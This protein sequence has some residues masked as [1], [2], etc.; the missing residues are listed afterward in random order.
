MLLSGLGLSAPLWGQTPPAEAAGQETETISEIRVRGAQKLSAETVS[1]KAGVKVGDDLRSMDFSAMLERLWASN[2]FDDVKLDVEET[3]KGSILIITVKER[4]IIKEIDYRGGTEI[5]VTTMKDKIKEKKLEAKA[6][7]IYDPEIARKIKNQIV[8]LA[9][10]KGF[11]NPVVEVV[12]EPM[13]PGVARLVFDV[14]EGGKIHIYKV[15]FRGNK[16]IKDAR[17]RTMMEKTRRHWM[18]SW[19]TNHDLLIDKNLEEDLENLKKAYWRLGYKDVFIGK[20][21]IT[22]EDL[23]T[24]RQ[25]K[26]NEKRVMN[27]KS[28]KYNLR[29]SLE[30]PILEGEQFYEGN[31][32]VEDA[33]AFNEKFLK[34]KYAEAK[35]ENHSKIKKFFGIKPPLEGPGPGKKVFFDMDAVAEA[36]KKIKEAYGDRAY[37][38]MF[39]DKTL[40]VRE[41]DG[42][43]KV[44]VTLKVKEGEVHTLRNLEFEGNTTTKD[45]VLRRSL[46]M[47]EGDNFSLSGFKDSMLRISQ[48]SYFD[49]K[50]SEPDIQPLPDKPQVDVKVKGE[51]AGVNEILFQGG[52][53]SV[54]GF[55]LGASFSTR[56][57]GGGGETLAV[58]YN[59]GK[60]QKSFSISFTEP[61]VFDLPYSFSTSLFNSSTDYDAS[62]VGIDNAYRQTTKGMGVSLGARFSNWFPDQRWAAFTTLG[63]GYNYRIIDIEGNKNYYYKDIRNQLTSSVAPTITYDTV[64]HPFKPTTGTKLSMSLEYG[65]WQLGGDH[66][67]LRTMLEATKFTNIDERHIFAINAS[68]GYMR[69]LGNEDLMPYE[70]FRPGG[71]NS[72]RGYRYGAVGSVQNDPFNRNIV[73]GGNKQF[74]TNL[75]YQ[76]KIADQFRFVTFY[77]MGNAWGPGT[78]IFTEGLRRS[79][80]LELR[81]FLPI[82]PAPM[83]LIWSRKLNPYTFDTD[84]RNDFQFS[85]GTT[86]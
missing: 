60:F 51:E 41:E 43:K 42:V 57:L 13:G 12:L 70:Y 30:I 64:N 17:L 63:V 82:S 38:R 53:G 52:Y 46:L 25:K 56:N 16:T 19:L 66:P 7:A 74:I 59:G 26:K 31:F 20:P 32:K 1:F 2:A 55:S 68:Y 39:S 40:E 23:T 6:D 50:N 8:D 24:A 69:R 84:G 22:V 61:Y 48:L 49:V 58:S 28:P 15:K 75:E 33:K 35:Q 62:R 85:M 29:A 78:K 54:F 5:G 65:G 83:R 73:V 11:R 80:G 4:P 71:E 3:D 21:T 67:Y 45:K 10:E 37:I 14:K 86:F 77:D 47:R 81:F 76:F 72:I 18:F 36:Q 34:L 9:A 27:G 79:M 44:D